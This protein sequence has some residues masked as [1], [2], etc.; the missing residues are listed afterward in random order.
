MTGMMTKEKPK[1]RER[2][3]PRQQPML[4]L[5]FECDRPLAGGLSVALSGELLIGRGLQREFDGDALRVPDELMSSRHSRLTPSAGSYMIED[6]GSKNGTVVNGVTTAMAKLR[7]GD[8]I[9]L[10]QSFFLYREQLLVPSRPDERPLVSTRR[11]DFASS[12]ADLGA[13]ARA[14]LPVLL[15]G[16][17]GTGKEVLARAVHEASERRGSFVAVNCGALPATLVESELFG[18]K[19]GAFSGAAED[20]PGLVRSADGGTLFLDEIGDLP[21]ASQAALL[22]VLQEREVTPV[23]ATRPVKVDLRIVAATHRDLR[24]LCDK[25]QFRTDLL[26]RLAGFTLNLPPLRERRED[27]GDLCAY[28][29]RLARGEAG[30]VRLAPEVARQL[31][32][33]AWPGNLRELEQ[34]LSAAALLARHGTIELEHLPETVRAAP[35]SASTPPPE[36]TPEQQAHR[37]ELEALLREHTG[38]ITVVAKLLGKTRMQIHRWMNRYGIDPASFRN[39]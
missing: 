5:V 33:Y 19:K 2:V 11:L 28:F 25:Q 3:A 36:L 35:L 9:E 8:L 27:L 7:D 26:Q 30:D 13:I 21:L 29:L 22:R 16:E 37:A 17:T 23:G 12:L 1:S 38:N 4:V 31:L 32:T 14:P 15:L 20:R 18:Y 39:P 24:K 34:A 6:L 10:G